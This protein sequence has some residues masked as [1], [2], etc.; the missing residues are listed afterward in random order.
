MLTLLDTVHF[1]GPISC[2][3][4]TQTQEVVSVGGTQ[5]G[6]S[7]LVLHLST[8]L[9]QPSARPPARESTVCHGPGALSTCEVS[10]TLEMLTF[11]GERPVYP[12]HDSVTNTMRLGEGSRRPRW[13]LGPD[14]REKP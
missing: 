4:R 3:L 12:D 1:A 10:P 9:Q 14:Q 5:L 13:R 2:E 7:V 11:T 8:C 6:P